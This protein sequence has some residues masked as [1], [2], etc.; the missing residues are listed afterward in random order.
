MSELSQD[1]RAN[2]LMIVAIAALM[3]AAWAI[4][5]APSSAAPAAQVP[6]QAVAQLQEVVVSD[7]SGGG[8]VEIFADYAGFDGESNDENHDKWIDVLTVEWGAEQAG[9][10]KKGRR[11]GAPVID[12]LVLTFEYEKASPKLEEKLLTGEV[13]PTLEIEFVGI[14]GGARATYLK[15]EM[16]NVSITSFDFS[17]YGNSEAGPPVVAFANNFEEIKV[18]Y[19]QYG[20]DGSNMGSVEYEY[21]VEQKKK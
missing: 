8:G 21:S 14:F 13:I 12:D 17:A 16:K 18:T 19:I 6:L 10:N 5:V 9:A 20:D 7:V 15:Y 4:A 3:I 2:R 1:R 11:R